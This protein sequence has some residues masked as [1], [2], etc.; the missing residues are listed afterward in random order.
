M[1]TS[2]LPIIA[3]VLCA[4]LIVA[5]CTDEDTTPPPPQPVSGSG[6]QPGALI[7]TFGN[8][9]GQGVIL[10]GVPRGTIDTVT[11][12]IGLAQG[13]KTLDMNGTTIAYADSVR[14]EILTPVQ[15]YFGNPPPGSWGIIDVADQLGGER[16]MRIDFEEKFVVR[17]NPKVP[18]ISDQVFTVSVRPP[19]GRPLMIRLIA[20]AE[21]GEQD[22]VLRPL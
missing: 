2:C 11:F 3:L 8:I 6:A 5:G 22:N 15:G 20:P 12:T 14:T 17:I 1:R 19:E 16:N 10:Q 7:Q 21:I 13:I 4:C 18:V 9:T